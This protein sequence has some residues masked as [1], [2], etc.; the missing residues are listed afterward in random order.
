M[1]SIHWK[2]RLF[3]KNL[4]YVI[5]DESTI[6]QANL[7]IFSL[8]DVLSRWGGD[9]FQLRAHIPDK[10][11]LECA[12]RI[13]RIIH[14]RGKTFIINNRLDICKLVGADG[15]HLGKEDIPPKEARKVLGDEAIIGKTV[16]SLDELK[17]FQRENVD[18]LSIGPVFKTEI[19]PNLNPLKE[20]E[21][22]SIIKYAK[23]PLFAIGG[24]N[25]N[26]INCLLSMGIKNVA[27]CRAL[28]STSD[29]RDTVIK[30]KQCLRKVY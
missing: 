20:K 22:K 18:Y 9:L 12:R 24:I 5:L 6:R 1:K 27:V 23:K 8:A 10:L 25:L 14:K 28:F 19:K 21:I 26:N 11:F 29:I 30:I 3:S 16:H 13:K 15:I 2:K 17:S 7:N 4:L